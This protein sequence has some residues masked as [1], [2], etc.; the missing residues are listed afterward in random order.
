LVNNLHE[1]ALEKRENISTRWI[2]ALQSSGLGSS[3]N[4]AK[5]SAQ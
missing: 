1:K 4:G 5:F 3:R 2:E